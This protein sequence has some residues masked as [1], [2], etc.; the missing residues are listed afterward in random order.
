MKPLLGL[1]TRVLYGMYG[2][3]VLPEGE[4]LPKRLLVAGRRLEK[5]TKD[6][7]SRLRGARP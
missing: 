5:H 3:T 7:T 4:L 6:M 1:C 2:P